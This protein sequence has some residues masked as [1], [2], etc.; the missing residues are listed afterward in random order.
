MNIDKEKLQGIIESAVHDVSSMATPWLDETVLI[1]EIK[2][3]QI[4]IKVTSEEGDFI[5]EINPNNECVTA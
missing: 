5:D 1:G 4:Q 3:L 2:G